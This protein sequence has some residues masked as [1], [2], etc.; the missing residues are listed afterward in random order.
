M[1]ANIS[2]GGG[3]HVAVLKNFA[4][5]TRGLHG[6]Q[7]REFGFRGCILE[8]EQPLQILSRNSRAGADQ[9]L[10]ENFF[11]S[12]GVAQFERRVGFG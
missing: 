2:G 8:F 3:H 10:D 4:E 6:S 5:L 11:C 7:E 12:I 1:R 9:I